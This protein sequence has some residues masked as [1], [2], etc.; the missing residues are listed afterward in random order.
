MD[1]AQTGIDFLVAMSVFLIVVGFVFAFVPS[2][3]APF[4]GSGVDD[5]LI[6]DRSATQLAESVLVA[7]PTHPGML[8]A[9]C[10][11]VFFDTDDQ[12]ENHTA[13]V[14]E[15]NCRFDPNDDLTALFGLQEWKSVRVTIGAPDN[16]TYEDGGTVYEIEMQRGDG[17]PPDGSDTVAQRVVLVDGDVYELRVRVW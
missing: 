16:V 12:L 8:S 11:A 3:F 13:L 14:D 15:H 10:T 9:A 4:G 1:R 2:M 6:A 7:E 17:S 5:A